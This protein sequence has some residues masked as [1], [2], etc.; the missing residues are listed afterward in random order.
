MAKKKLEKSISLLSF[1]PDELFENLDENS[2][3]DIY[4]WCS[5]MFTNP[6]FKKIFDE[7][8]T[9]QIIA[10]VG[11]LDDLND[12]IEAR[13]IIFGIAG[14]KD[15]FQKYHQLHL[16]ATKSDEEMTTQEKHEIV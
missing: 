13:G 2:K 10:T 8:Y 9:N 4:S 5:I 15:I 7:L 11:K 1:Q 14:V 12:A 6:L 16:E 3:K